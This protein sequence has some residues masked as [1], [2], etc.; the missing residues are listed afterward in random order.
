MTR[1]ENK[2]ARRLPD[3]AEKLGNWASFF[4]VGAAARQPVGSHSFNAPLDLGQLPDHLRRSV[5]EPKAPPPLAVQ[6][7]LCA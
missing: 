4:V 6:V 5:F 1:E 2:S 3:F 7:L